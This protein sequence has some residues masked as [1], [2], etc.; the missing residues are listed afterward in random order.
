MT[1]DAE[2]LWSASLRRHSRTLAQ[3]RLRSPESH[4]GRPLLSGTMTTYAVK[5]REPDGQTFVQDM[6][7]FEEAT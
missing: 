6:V 2:R 3:V 1:I 7:T 5:W 4:E